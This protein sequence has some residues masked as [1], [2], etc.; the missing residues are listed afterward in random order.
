MKK[1]LRQLI[2]WL[3]SHKDEEWGEFSYK[4]EYLQRGVSRCTRCK[5]HRAW[6]RLTSKGVDRELKRAFMPAMREAVYAE[7]PLMRRVSE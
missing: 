3:C 7:N 2:C 6:V 5:R 1:H 4:D